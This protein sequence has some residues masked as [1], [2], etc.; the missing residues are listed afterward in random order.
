MASQPLS[1]RRPLSAKTDDRIVRVMPDIRL[2]Q[3]RDAAH[4]APMLDK[5][6]RTLTKIRI[7]WRNITA[8]AQP[9]P[10]DGADGGIAGHMEQAAINAIRIFADFL[11]HQNMVGEI[12]L[13]RGAE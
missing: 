6:L 11:D 10:G 12:G 8:P 4:R 3:K 7:V 2:A 13:E 9:Y 5:L 1:N